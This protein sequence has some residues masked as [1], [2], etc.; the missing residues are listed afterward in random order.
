M[1]ERR[2]RTRFTLGNPLEAAIYVLHDVTVSDHQ[3]SRL[4]VLAPLPVPSGEVLVL[5]RWARDGRRAVTVRTVSSERVLAVGAP[6]YRLRLEHL[7]DTPD[8]DD[9]AFEDA[10]DRLSASIVRRIPARVR[11]LGAGGC[12]IE[13]TRPVLVD[14]VGLVDVAAGRADA[15][16]FQAVE[17][18]WRQ[19]HTYPCVVHATF[20]TL[21]APSARSLR[22]RAALLEAEHDIRPLARPLAVGDEPMRWS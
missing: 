6:R 15:D 2:A 16:A 3:A 5:E 8:P 22:H 10:A 9:L 11:D 18:R 1:S 7:V 21:A 13:S 12:C 14:T 17:T 19:G 4:E 20:L